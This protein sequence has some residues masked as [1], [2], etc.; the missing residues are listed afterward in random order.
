MNL[1]CQEAR[2]SL[3][4]Q[5]CPPARVEGGPGRQLPGLSRRFY[6]RVRCSFARSCSNAATSCFHPIETTL[7]KILAL[8]SLQRPNHSPLMF[9]RLS[10]PLAFLSLAQNNTR[11]LQNSQN[12]PPGG[13]A[14]CLNPSWK[15]DFFYAQSWLGLQQSRLNDFTTGPHILEKEMETPQKVTDLFTSN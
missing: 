2:R 1:T 4:Q 9:V 12:P 3:E 13:Q 6:S 5:T 7:E 10:H 11:S 8:C 15:S 14:V